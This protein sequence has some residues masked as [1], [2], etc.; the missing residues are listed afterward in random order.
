MAVQNC[1]GVSLIELCRAGRY[2][3]AQAVAE[4]LSANTPEIVLGL[5]MVEIYRGNL[6]V[7]KDLLSDLAFQVGDLADRAKVH[8]SHAY[9]LSGEVEEA[10][11]ILKQVPDGFEKLL[12]KAILETRPKY[13]LKILDKAA[14]FEVRPGMQGRVHNRRALIFRSLGEPDRAIQEYEAALFFFEQD[15][16]DCAPLVLNNLARVY[17]EFNELDRAL[18]YAERAI[19]LLQDDPPHL[20]KA[21]D[22]KA[23]ILLAQGQTE[24]A[25]KISRDAV[26]V[27]RRS[28][29]KE[30]L[31]ESLLTHARMLRA[32][33]NDHEHEVLHEAEANCRYL[34]RADLLVDVLKAK[35]ELAEITW[36]RAER[37][38]IETALVACG[39]S[40]R[41]VAAKLGTHHQGISRLIQ[42]HNISPKN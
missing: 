22:E 20:G 14:L 4:G 40:V 36:H 12:L 1:A 19:T 39:G 9:Q 29:R 17:T 37:R 16:S 25:I 10:K 5:G 34:D 42:R 24:S 38:L 28:D 3:E 27:L 23:R 30:W 13:A 11:D 15:G 26:S 18:C 41:R 8:L 33:S 2:R 31:I 35:A 6:G 7:A 32:A 21:L